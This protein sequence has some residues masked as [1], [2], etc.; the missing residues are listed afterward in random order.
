MKRKNAL[1]ISFC[2]LA[3]FHGMAYAE[4]EEEFSD[5]YLDKFNDY[6]VF[7]DVSKKKQFLTYKGSQLSSIT[8]LK[9]TYRKS[10]RYNIG[11]EV[12]V[13]SL[14]YEDLWYHD[15]RPVG[16]RRYAQLE[17]AKMKQGSILVRPS[18]EAL[19]E[20]YALA[21]AI[22]KLTVELSLKDVCLTGAYVPKEMFRDVVSAMAKYDFL[23]RRETL[24]LGPM[25]T[26][27]MI[28]S[29]PSG[30]ESVLYYQRRW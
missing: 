10:P 5:S 24:K 3:F 6:V 9:V 2:I 16:S 13:K 14:K 28:L 26:S 30:L 23:Q 17:I 7:I 25:Q 8:N 21:N 4:P 27:V 12:D 20:P 29:N 1:T 15:G 11:S 18:E 22:V 19:R